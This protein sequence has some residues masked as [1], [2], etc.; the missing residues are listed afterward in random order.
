MRQQSARLYSI[1]WD[2]HRYDLGLSGTKFTNDMGPRLTKPRVTRGSVLLLNRACVSNESRMTVGDVGWCGLAWV[3]LGVV[4][5]RPGGG[6]AGSH[7]RQ[8]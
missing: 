8:T 6:V 4:W 2:T 3:W 7:P 5:G 1:T